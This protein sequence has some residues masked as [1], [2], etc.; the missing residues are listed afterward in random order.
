MSRDARVERLLEEMLNSGLTPEEVAGNSPDLLEEVRER[1]NHLRRIEAQLQTLFPPSEEVPSEVPPPPPPPPPVGEVR[2]ADIPGYE[3]TEILGR[4]G[5]GI[6]YRGIHRKLDRA[7][8]IKMLLASR[9]ATS[10]ERAMLAREAQ[11]IAGL[12]HPNIVQV[13]DVGEADG[14][15]YFTMEDMDG[16]T[17]AQKLAGAPMSVPDAAATIVTLARAVEAAH[18]SGI[19]H[20]DLKPANVLL[21]ADGALKVSDFGLARRF[22]SN[23]GFSLMQTGARIGTPSYMAPEQALGQRDS[24]G[25]A[26]DIYSLGAILYELLTGR[27]P[28]VGDSVAETERQ[29]LSQEPVP[30]S[31]LNSRVPRDL[32][33]IC[34]KCLHKTPSR[35]YETA[36]RLAEDVQRFLRNEPITA[37]RAGRVERVAKW[38]RRYP[39]AT[40]A[41]G[42]LILLLVVVAVVTARLVWSRA[43][44]VRDVNDDLAAIVRGQRAGN[45]N[46]AR[47]ALERAKGRL[48]EQRLPELRQQLARAESELDLVARLAAIRLSRAEVVGRTQYNEADRDYREAFA[49]AGLDPQSRPPRETAA[50][51]AASPVRGPLI[52]ALDDWG[53]WAKGQE[54]RELILEIARRADPDPQWRDRARDRRCAGTPPRSIS[55]PPRRRSPT[56]PSRC[57]L[58]SATTSGG[59]GQF[60]GLLPAHPARTPGRL[61]GELHAGV[62]PARAT[63]PGGNHLL[64]GSAGTAA[65]HADRLREPDRRIHVP[66]TAP[67]RHRLR[68]PRR[69]DGPARPGCAPQP[70]RRPDRYRAGRRG[71]CRLREGDRTR[72][73][74]CAG[75]RRPRPGTV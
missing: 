13:F 75:A 66:G 24:V 29:L 55:S 30:P 10:R 46:E 7:V 26:A 36:G 15:P 63:Q 70:G 61:L 54:Q 42:A 41:A 35:R 12:R 69:P 31:R 23:D 39:G 71:D 20:R 9:H 68:A 6:V 8:A 32:E 60:D 17:L 21:T 4:G 49:A 50:R 22:E 33:T 38:A 2:L 64:P 51:I 72:P 28:F 47:Q 18:C 48:G 45:W 74:L 73:E 16:G 43:Q 44:V 67:R 53:V 62:R 52:A 65:R 11:A 37:R 40:T 57:S 14:C 59:E 34:L 1:W 27:P 25:P 5:M 58:R 19:I 56:S 3:V